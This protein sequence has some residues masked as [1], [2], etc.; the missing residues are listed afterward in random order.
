MKKTILLLLL[1]SAFLFPLVSAVSFGP[2]Y[3]IYNVSESSTQCRGIHYS[4]V[5]SLH[6]TWSKFAKQ[7]NSPWQLRLI[8]LDPEERNLEVTFTPTLLIG[9]LQYADLCI[10]NNGANPQ[11]RGAFYLRWQQQG[12]TVIQ[13]AI[14]LKIFT[15]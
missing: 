1:A 11:S 6:S 9:S 15:Y 3:L 13:G 5:P 10:T 4:T 7:D 8:T 2:T 14:W 12:N